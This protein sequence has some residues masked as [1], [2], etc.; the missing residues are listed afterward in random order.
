[1]AKYE[2]EY[3]DDYGYEGEEGSSASK[4]LKGYKLMVLLLAVILV[5]VSGL[6]F[7][8]SHQIRADFAIERDTLTNRILAVRNDLVNLETTNLALGDSI[9]VERGRVDSILDVIAKERRVTRSMIREYESKLNIMR[10]AAENFIYQIDSLNQLN[11]RLIGENL[12]MRRDIAV[13][14]L[15]ADAAVERAEDADI[16]IRQGSVIIG[17]DIRLTPLNSNNR[18]V[19]RVNRAA[20]LRI[21]LTLSAN[22]LANPGNRPIYAQIIGP[23][24]YLLANPQAATFDHEGDPLVYSAVREVD[25]QNSDLQVGIFYSG[26]DIS[27]GTYRI[28]IYMDGTLIGSAEQLLR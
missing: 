15:R 20:S 12:G 18:E 17:R 22:N 3:E 6:Y 23:E 27:A 8:Q 21:D 24:G 5:A 26:S 9:A 19:T 2:D 4:S 25:Y 1:M 28:A 14:R 11:E 10:A 7:Y 13:E 16:K